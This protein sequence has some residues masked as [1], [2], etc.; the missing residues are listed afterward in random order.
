[1]TLTSQ[2]R[3]FVDIATAD[4]RILIDMR[5]ASEDNFMKRA[6]YPMA[7]C[8]LRRK[9]VQRL[10]RVQDW[11]EKRELRLKILDAYRPLHVQRKLWEILPDDRYVAPPE[12][13]SKHNRG[14][15]VDITLA[16]AQGR[17]LV[18][19]TG[20][21]DFTANAHWSCIDLPLEA[22]A[23]RALLRKAMEMRGFMTYAFEWWHFDDADWSLYP[24]EDL[25]FE[26]LCLS[27]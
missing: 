17:E 24:I 22:L 12:K 19:P 4:P 14:A 27:P 8:F 21:D 2:D 11:L 7:K 10:S 25:A 23:N 18:M 20:Y 6:V 16:D 5:Y 15:A 13:G 9:V 26:E 3:Q 1:M